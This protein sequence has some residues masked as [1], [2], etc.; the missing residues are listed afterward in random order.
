MHLIYRT[1]LQNSVLCR[2]LRYSKRPRSVG[3]T[4][5]NPFV[6]ILRR[7]VGMGN[8]R[9]FASPQVPGFKVSRYER[10]L[11]LFDAYMY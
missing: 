2:A 3:H 5:L 6:D 7:M 10:T 11:G 9:K 1:D 4:I 8:S